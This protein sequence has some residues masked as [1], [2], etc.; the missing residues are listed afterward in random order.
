M[1]TKLYP[2]Y[3][4]GTI[5]A[6]Y[7][8]GG[9]AILT[10]PFSM[11]RAVG[12]NEF[13]GFNL[14]VKTVQSSTYII[15][16]NSYD[17]NGY[18]VRFIIN[19][20]DKLNVGQFYK[21]QIAYIDNNGIIGHYSTIGV[22]KFTTKP[23]LGISNLDHTKLNTH[24]YD[25]IGFYSQENGDIT[26]RVYKSC[27]KVWDNE[28]KLIAESGDILHNRLED[29]N[30]Y[31]SVDRWSLNR[32]LEKDKSYYIQY[33]VTTLNGMAIG[34]PKYRIMQKRSI[35]SNLK[36]KLDVSLN[37]DNGY[38]DLNLIGNFDEDGIEEP[39]SGSYL[40]SRASSKDKFTVW[41]KIYNFTLQ[42]EKPSRWLWRDFT[43]EQGVTYIYSIQQ[44]NDNGLYSERLLSKEITADFE[45]SFLFDGNRQLRIRFNP[46]VSSFKTDILE[47]K[48]DTLGGKHPFIFR[49][50][51][52]SYKDFPISGLISYQMDEENF[53]ISEEE[54]ALKEKTQNF[55]RDNIYSER[56]FKLEVLNWLNN[57]KP[58]IFRSPTEGNYIVRLMNI[59]LSPNDT[60]GRMLHTFNCNA[61]EVAEYSYENLNNNNFIQYTKPSDEKLRW[62]TI[63]FFSLNGNIYKYQLQDGYYELLEKYSENNYLLSKRTAQTAIFKD[64]MPGS[65]IKIKMEN[66]NSHEEI[67]IGITGSYQ[68]E[69]DVPIISIKIP[70]DL[71]KNSG[72][73]TY[74]YYS[75]AQNIFE[76]IENVE[77]EETP[78]AQF[79]GEH[80][81]II[82]KIENVKRKIIQF[83]NLNFS[84]RPVEKAYLIND[85]L[86]QDANGTILL[87]DNLEP[88]YV[89]E[90]YNGNKFVYYLD[91][92]LKEKI[93]KYSTKF[94]LNGKEI[95]LKEIETYHLDGIKQIDK[96]SIG[97]GVSVEAS[98]QSQIYTYNIENKDN[99]ITISDEVL[100]NNMWQTKEELA[101]AEINYTNLLNNYNKYDASYEI[102]LNKAREDA[103]DKYNKYIELLT[104]VLEIYKED[105]VLL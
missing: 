44:Y 5:P 82:E 60:L 34:S 98:Y 25:Y 79:I 2:P 91:G 7:S 93:T 66:S 24:R 20:L 99:G 23:Q 27:F 42:A 57:G 47:S 16:V 46:K 83:F 54:I 75:V 95:D 39:E 74:S 103:I 1:M 89:Y 70:E 48:T 36:A 67:Q 87:E 9:T 14:K 81:N 4:E 56:N 85:K 6:F 26:E 80:S 17:H 102:V 92:N 88:F 68:I 96:I 61:Y 12:L 55:T 21:L 100:L 78:L 105:K 29:I 62:E 90:V 86:Y 69:L 31:E 33:I 41:N 28:D 58:K 64:L 84:K 13:K 45:D 19:S 51:H 97:S 35:E 52:V 43:V 77:V 49:N 101:Q 76:L 63:E 50:G 72:N 59:N 73:L 18:E 53:F 40:I 94:S 22:V 65:R 15:N 3:I 8:E 11:N 10:V 30:S 38:I 37:F 104:Q 71:I 32:E